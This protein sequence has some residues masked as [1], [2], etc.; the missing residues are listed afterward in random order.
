MPNNNDYG[1]FNF[2]SPPDTQRAPRP[3]GQPPGEPGTAADRQANLAPRCVPGRGQPANCQPT[4][5]GGTDNIWNICPFTFCR[6]A[7]D[8]ASGQATWLPCG[9]PTGYQPQYPPLSVPPGSG[10]KLAA[11]PFPQPPEDNP[12]QPGE[13]LACADASPSDSSELV[14]N[15]LPIVIEPHPYS[16]GEMARALPQLIRVAVDGL[17]ELTATIKTGFDALIQTSVA[18]MIETTMP[19]E[20]GVGRTIDAAGTTLAKIKGKLNNQLVSSVAEATAY[21]AMLG[22]PP[23]PVQPT[24]QPPNVQ[25]FDPAIHVKAGPNGWGVIDRWAVESVGCLPEMP[26]DIG[27]SNTL[28]YD[29]DIGYQGGVCGIIKKDPQGDG[30]GQWYRIPGSICPPCPPK[31]GDNDAGAG[32]DFGGGDAGAG[33]DFNDPGPPGGQID[34]RPSCQVID[35]THVQV[36]LPGGGSQIME[37]PDANAWCGVGG[38]GGGLG[39][40]GILD[41]NQGGTLDPNP[42]GTLFPRPGGGINN[43][44]TPP[45]GGNR[46]PCPPPVVNCPPGGGTAQPGGT[47]INNNFPPSP[48]GSGTLVTNPPGGTGTL[49]NTTGGANINVVVNVPPPPDPSLKPQPFGTDNSAPGSWVYTDFNDPNACNLVAIANGTNALSTNDIITDNLGFQ[50]EASDPLVPQQLKD[51]MAVTPWWFPNKIVWALCRTVVAVMNPAASYAAGSFNTART[52]LTQ[53]FVSSMITGWAARITGGDF[54]KL[55]QRRTITQNLLAPSEPPSVAD[56]SLCYFAGEIDQK[57]WTCWVRANN[58]CDIPYQTVLHASRT[59]PGVAE[60]LGLW[61]RGQI[62]EPHLSLELRNLGVIDAKD[63]ERY[64]SLTAYVPSPNEVVNIMA[65]N[66]NDDDAAAANGFDHNFDDRYSGELKDYLTSRGVSEKQARMLWREHWGMP[67]NGELIEMLF[68]LR[69]GA[70][71]PAGSVTEDDI[72]S[73]LQNNG[74]APE[75]IERTIAVAR[76]RITLREL[77]NLVVHAAWD[78]EKLTSAFMNMGYTEEQSKDLAKGYYGSFIKGRLAEMG[79]PSEAEITK[80]YREDSA[81][82]D[83]ATEILKMYG[84]DDDAVDQILDIQDEILVSQMRAQNVKAVRSRYMKGEYRDDEAISALIAAGLTADRAEKRVGYW[85]AERE[86]DFKLPSTQ[87]LCG[88][89]SDG[90]IDLSTYMRRMTNLGYSET[91]A[92]ALVGRCVIAENTKRAAEIKKELK[93]QEAAISKQLREAKAAAKEAAA[94][95][96]ANAPCRPKPKPQCP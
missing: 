93:E 12:C 17:D 70:D 86:L 4:C 20:G 45:G 89:Y 55:N 6:L 64:K 84:H 16:Q 28:A 56:A 47:I 1:G 46:P 52:Y 39:G 76:P 57:T 18:H 25:T 79:V 7:V 36:N 94:R 67:S 65:G 96:K 27:G 37:V 22:I 81:T 5:G 24:P 78:E 54:N 92:K 50:G 91:D 13:Q 10:G 32:G 15:S 43:I 77:R 59:R 87:Q 90:F 21:A 48:A 34:N 73:A 85:H 33:G 80:L 61:M 83:K 49:S 19:L 53:G 82:R 35:P 26:F 44:P 69:P 58:V 29:P 23:T 71:N 68:R 42:G 95:A 88:M 2:D 31:T 11:N 75:W 41:P 60:I 66:R 8:P 62:D 74:L 3:A 72:R 40:Y 14:P 9:P 63:R 51:L 30:V 38:G